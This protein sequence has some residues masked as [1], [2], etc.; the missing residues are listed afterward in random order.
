MGTYN[1]STDEVVPLLE[2]WLM[3]IEGEVRFSELVQ[4]YNKLALKYGWND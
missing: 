4:A 2:E 3:S 1:L